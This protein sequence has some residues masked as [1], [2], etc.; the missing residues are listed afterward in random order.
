ML[1]VEARKSEAKRAQGKITD[2]VNV[3]GSYVGC[4]LRWSRITKIMKMENWRKEEKRKTDKQ[5][6]N[7][8]MKGGI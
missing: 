7:A 1:E 4:T 3:M 5:W 8:V 6:I 2:V